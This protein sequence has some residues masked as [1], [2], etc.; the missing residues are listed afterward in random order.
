MPSNESFGCFVS[1]TAA[2]SSAAQDDFRKLFFQ[3]TYG[4]DMRGQSLA[5]EGQM[6]SMEA[7]LTMGHKSNKYLNYQMKR[8]PNFSKEFC[9]YSSDYSHKPNG[10]NHF[11]SHLRERLR[12]TGSSGS[13]IT[14]DL[15][16]TKTNYASDFARHEKERMRSAKQ[17][18]QYPPHRYC[19]PGRMLVT[20]SLSQT[21]HSAPSPEMNAKGQ[22]LRPST[23]FVRSS[24]HVGDFLKTTYGKDFVRREAHGRLR[25]QHSHSEPAL[26]PL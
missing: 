15:P 1:Q 9:G 7:V 13:L 2:R 6:E 3:T 12:E 23:C 16:F 25:S 8:V 11:N 21:M 5:P 19:D 14:A 20:Q 22:N 24:S 26:R 10:D 17:K 18:C 4:G